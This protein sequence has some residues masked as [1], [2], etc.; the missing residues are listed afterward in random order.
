LTGKASTKGMD[1]TQLN[2]VL[3]SMKKKGFRVKPARKASSGLPLD[4]HPQSR[5]IRALWLEMAAAGI[6]RDRSE[7]ALA[8]WIKRETGISALRWL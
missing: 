4:N 3:E 2:C 5:K 7:N 6:V 8:R 1:T